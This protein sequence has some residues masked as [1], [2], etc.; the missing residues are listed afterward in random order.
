[1]LISTVE[2]ELNSYIRVLQYIRLHFPASIEN[3]KKTNKPG[4]DVSPP[5]K[6]TLNFDDDISKGEDL[7]Y[8]LTRIRFWTG[9]LF[10]VN[11]HSFKRTELSAWM[12][13]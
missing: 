12:K 1:M 2:R 13:K 7:C 5:D 10:T 8:P 9:K 11:L 4:T 3:S 6:E